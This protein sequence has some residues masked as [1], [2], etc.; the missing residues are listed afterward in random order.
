MR[1]HPVLAVAAALVIGALGY[2]FS[3]WR[4]WQTHVSTDDAF[5]EARVSPVSARVAGHVLEVLVNDN[6]EVKAG[7]PIVRLDPRDYEVKLQQARAA[8]VMAQAG[9]KGAT[10]SVPM[11]EESTVSG[12]DQGEAALHAATLSVE[13]AGSVLEEKRGLLT[14]KRAAV[15]TAR[16]AVQSAEADFERAQ[17]ERDRSKQLL[18][19]TL[20]A[21]RDFDFADAGFKTARATLDAARNRLEEAQAETQRVEAEMASQTLALAQS[22]RRVEE[23]RAFLAQAR[24]QRRQVGIRRA[25][26][27]TASG[28]LAESLANLREAELKLDYTTIRAPLHGRVT[29]KTVEVGQV[30]QPGQP[31]LAVVSMDD[32][33]VVANYKETELTHVRPG[34][35]VII[36]VDTYPGAKFKGRVDSIQAGTGSRFSLLP[37][38]NASGNFVKVVQRI[39]V[40][41]VLDPDTDR[42]HLLVPGMSVVPTVQV[43]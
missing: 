25:E 10:A 19:R 17:L 12:V 4:Y 29:K 32:V 36:T 8:V 26:A 14:G 9:E 18:E 39:P 27:E 21:Q 38:E 13:L 7:E 11:S 41:L 28:R 37:P 2:G 22:R 35:P 6:Q 42:Q 34:Q 43:R 31:L 33:W 20:V 3:V 23:S 1:R 16:A 15:A 24:S 30:V 5:V 40:K